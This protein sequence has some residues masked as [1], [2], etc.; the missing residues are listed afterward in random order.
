MKFYNPSQQFW[1]RKKSFGSIESFG[2]RFKE[3]KTD[4]QK[5]KECIALTKRVEPE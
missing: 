2:N 1:G 5:G 3:Q 4:L